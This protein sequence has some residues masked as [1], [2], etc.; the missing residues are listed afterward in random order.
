MLTCSLRRWLFSGLRHRVTWQ[1]FTDVSE[2]RTASIVGLMVGAVSGCRELA[3]FC[4]TT[5]R[6]Y[7]EDN[8]FCAYRRENLKPYL[9]S[10]NL[11]FVAVGRIDEDSCGGPAKNTAY[12]WKSKLLAVALDGIINYDQERAHDRQWIVH[13]SDRSLSGWHSALC[14]KSQ[15]LIGTVIGPKRLTR[16]ASKT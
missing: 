13:F 3:K 15:K 1:T 16:I 2:I 9:F 6:R 5:W 11:Q 4:Q 7:P 14:F 12:F 8:C 10:H